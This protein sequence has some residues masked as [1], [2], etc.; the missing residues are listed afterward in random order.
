[1]NRILLVCVAACLFTT[2]FAQTDTTGK[3]ETNDTIR[4]GGMIIVKKPGSN[5]RE[6]ITGDRTVK[7]PSRKRESENENVTTNWSILDIGFSGF[8]D[9]TNYSSP[10]AQAFAPGSTEDWFD[11]RGKSRN[12]NFW[13]FM[14]R[15][16]MI[17]HVVNL[18]YGLGLELNNY[19]FDDE[20]IRF[21]KN[22]TLITMDNNLK[23]AK[24]NK[25]AVDYLTAP[26][27]LNFNFTPNRQNG[28]GFSAG[29]SAGYLY[30]A[31]QKTKMGGDK[32]KVRNDFDLKRWKLSYVG[33]LNLG[34]VK[35][36]G[37]YAFETMW[38][39]GLDQ[40]PYNVGFRLS[41]W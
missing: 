24:K 19:F 8:N 38:D 2:G 14:Q 21:Q 16:N 27:M 28:F 41:N 25:L 23:D 39:K 13:F 34:P 6:I 29:V 7:I 12:I 26:I 20:R 31:R 30:S 33:E 22:P 37:S 17:K 10:E 4:I 15:L 3:K 1:M 36:Y 9:Q 40:T 35:L 18:K 32:D 5:D 11:L